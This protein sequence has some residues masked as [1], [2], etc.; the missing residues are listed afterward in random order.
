M[1]EQERTTYV[2]S[3][4]PLLAEFDLQP[5]VTDAHSMVSHI[6]VCPNVLLAAVVLPASFDVLFHFLQSQPLV[7]CYFS[8]VS[9][10]DVISICFTDSCSKVAVRAGALRGNSEFGTVIYRS[11]RHVFTTNIWFP[12]THLILM[13][14][15]RGGCGSNSV[16]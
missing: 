6:K 13:F 2:Q 5:P 3:L 15:L 10:N 12:R 14:R 1:A 4:M 16:G 8:A 9:C 11:A 7:C